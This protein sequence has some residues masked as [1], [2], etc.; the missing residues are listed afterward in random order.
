MPAMYMH[1]LSAMKNCERHKNVQPRNNL[2][3]SWKE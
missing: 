1:I 3:L 2:Q